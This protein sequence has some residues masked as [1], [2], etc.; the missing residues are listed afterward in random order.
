MRECYDEL[1][2]APGAPLRTVDEAFEPASLFIVE[3]QRGDGWLPWLA[4]FPEDDDRPGTGRAQLPSLWECLIR[5]LELARSFLASVDARQSGQSAPALE[6]AIAGRAPAGVIDPLEL[7]DSAAR[8]LWGWMR[9]V[10]R[11]TYDSALAAALALTAS[12]DA[13]VSRHDT[14]AHDRLLE[15]VDVAADLARRDL[16]RPDQLSDAARREW[17]LA[18]ILLACVRGVLRNRLL[19]HPDGL[20]AVDDDDFVDWLIRNGAAP[21]SARCALVKTV[22]YDLQFAYQNGDGATPRCSAATALRG[23]IRLFF[24]YRGA[25][26]WKMRAGMGDVVFAPLW[27]VLEKR[28]VRFEFF[29]RVEALRLSENGHRIAR[30][31]VTRQVELRDPQAGY[32]P[33]IDVKGLPCWPNAPLVGQLIDAEDLSRRPEEV[34]SFWSRRRTAGTVTLEDGKDFDIVV[35]AIP[36]GA[37]PYI[38]RD[39]MERSPA[40][41]GM[42]DNLETIYTQAFQL[43][44]SVTMERLGCDWPQ[45]TTGG[46]REPFDT[47]ADMRQLIVSEDW[48]PPNSVEA[49]AYFCNAMPTPRQLPDRGDYSLPE[50]A[51]LKVQR[52]VVDFLRD[53]MP[54]LWPRGVE[55]YPTG[56][57]WDWLVGDGPDVQGEAR[58]DSQFWRANID[59]SER[60]VL[61][62]PGTARHRLAPDRS[63][64]ENLFLAGDWTRCGLNAGCVE[65]AVI[66]GRVAAH[67]IGGSPPLK[68]IV[69]YSDAAS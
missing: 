11:T 28:G 27:A 36:V 68:E 8:R 2:R 20:D 29:H 66:S 51:H 45:A 42:V 13:D 69:G 49:I 15:L 31:E 56:F 64:Y 41:Q 67:A 54:P 37:H 40:W 48:Q 18:D 55:R 32:R 6:F 1:G 63:G 23:L 62:L 19:I 30:I 22:V 33:L 43:W 59:P 14:G 39:L 44:L 21:A 46:Y 9:A 57:R 16:P 4:T 50:E 26:A 35:L 34:E 53:Q 24:T 47:Y 3:E 60:Y 17:Y 12:L 61:S 25:I 58:F 65:S 38:C 5:A 7:L 10:V 52:T